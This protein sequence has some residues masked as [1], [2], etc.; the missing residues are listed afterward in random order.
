MRKIFR[1]TS[2]LVMSFLFTES[3]NALTGRAG[4]TSLRNAR[5]K[6]QAQKS[7]S[8]SQRMFQTSNG[9]GVSV[10]RSKTF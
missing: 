1:F 9:C 4:S 2:I 5:H 10:Q 7:Q 6:V 8:T 3:S